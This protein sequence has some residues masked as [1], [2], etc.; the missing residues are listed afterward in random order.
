MEE[1]Y[2][3]WKREEEDLVEDRKLDLV[4]NHTEWL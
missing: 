3:W 1:F 2:D 4:Y